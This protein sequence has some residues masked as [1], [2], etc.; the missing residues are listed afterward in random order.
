MVD[1]T[2]TD[3]VDVRKLNASTPS[4][5]AEAFWGKELEQV[6]GLMGVDPK[7]FKEFPVHKDDRVPRQGFV[8]DEIDFLK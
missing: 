3:D 1:T 8:L 7:I 5:R 6:E 4:A 2:T